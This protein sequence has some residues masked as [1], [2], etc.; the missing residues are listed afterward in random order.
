MPFLRLAAVRRVLAALLLFCFGTYGVESEVADVHDRQVAHDNGAADHNA[1]SAGTGS[2]VPRGSDSGTDSH[3]IHL[4]HCTHTHA[5]VL[6]TAPTLTEVFRPAP[7]R[8][9]FSSD[10]SPSVRLRP[11]L[12]PPIA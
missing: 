8:E 10:F 4:C 2:Q 3:P 5:G 6:G 12:R 11:P 7:P 9:W 1:G